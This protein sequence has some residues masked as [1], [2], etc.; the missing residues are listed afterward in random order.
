MT[1][2]HIGVVVVCTVVVVVTISPG[3]VV[4][5]VRTV[6]DSGTD[7]TVV[8]GTEIHKKVLSNIQPMTFKK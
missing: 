1:T 7:V 3:D 2:V 5:V 6:V 4:L 8:V